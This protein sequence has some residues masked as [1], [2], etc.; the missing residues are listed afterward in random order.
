MLNQT[1]QSLVFQE[2]AQKRAK[3][4]LII[5]TPT[6]GLR[7]MSEAAAILCHGLNATQAV[8][9][10]RGVL[11]LEIVELCTEIVAAL[12]AQKDVEA[13]ESCEQYRL[14]GYPEFPVMLRGF[15]LPDPCGIS[16]ARILIQMERM[17]LR[18]EFN[19]S[20]AVKEYVLSER[21]QKVLQHLIV[22]LT[23]KEIASQLGLTEYSVKEHVKRLMRKMRSTTRAGLV[24]RVM[25]G[26]P[27]EP[28]R[29][30]HSLA[31]LP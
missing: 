28:Q 2:I 4:G 16:Q 29:T 31:L 13:W 30:R 24:S 1:P 20:R 17:V 12:K 14:V 3:P 9:T 11:P 10:P 26:P 19:L 5:F 6:M 8:Y 15:G 25:Q 22:G 7:H 27:A 23:N 21:E 18:E